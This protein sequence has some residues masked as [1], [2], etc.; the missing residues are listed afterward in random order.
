MSLSRRNVLALVG[1]GT[2]IA[3][4][5]A[6][7]GFLATRTP[8]K[9][10]APW[11]LAG[12]YDDPRKNALS[13]ALLAPNPH[14]I[15]PWLI[16][17]DGDDTVIIHRDENRGLPETDPF[18]RQ[19]TI[20][21]GCFLEQMSIAAS[22]VGLTVDAELFPDGDDGPVARCTFSSG[23]SPDALA[24]H[25]MERRSYKETFDERQLSD[26]DVAPLREFAT[27][28]VTADE[29]SNLKRIATDAWLVE[30]QTPA[31]LKESI[32]LLRIGKAEVNANPDGIDLSGAFFDALKFAGLAS[33]E[34]AMDPNDPNYQQA[35]QGMVDAVASASAFS[36]SVTSGNTRADQIQAGREWLRL[37]LAATRA[38]IHI[39]PVSQALQE[40]SE[41]KEQ[42]DA[43]HRLYAPD[44]GTVQMLG[45]L[46]YG[47]QVPRTPRW[48]LE[49]K[50]MDA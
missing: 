34:A 6:T 13:Y 31:K 8:E 33:R 12:Q 36:V 45:I 28:V 46:G 38:G 27:M 7:T 47:P 29:V 4:G 21:F 42:Y 24:A 1:G 14:N 49:A 37:N 50:M 39:R 35:V 32:D 16:E 22:T 3:A 11:G 19:I 10:L 48:P 30:M 18:D 25:I 26:N 15:Q 17:L 44:G 9:A 23:G 40:Y 20:G 41:V 2:V 43:I 5:G